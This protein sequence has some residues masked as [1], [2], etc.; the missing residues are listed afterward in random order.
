[1]HRLANELRRNI[2]T[3]LACS[4]CLNLT[5]VLVTRRSSSRATPQSLRRGQRWPLWAQ[6]SKT[7]SEWLS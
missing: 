2:V 5:S 6:T 3:I 4:G 7:S 1:M